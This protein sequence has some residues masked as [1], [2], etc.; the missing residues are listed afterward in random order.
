M[1][2]G[3]KERRVIDDM[4]DISA[5]HNGSPE[6]TTLSASSARVKQG[7][8]AL[9]FTN[10]VDYTKGEKNYPVG[11]PRADKNL[12]KMKLTDWSGYDFFECWV[13]AETSRESLPSVP[14]NVGFY[15]TGPKRSTSVP[16]G[17]VEKD[18]WVKIAIPISTLSDVA[19]IQRVQFSISEANY[20]HGDR[21]DFYIDDMVL[22]RFVQPAIAELA[23][24]RK[25]LYADAPAV[26]ASYRL[27]GYKGMDDV[28]A[29]FEIDHEGAPVATTAAKAARSGELTL[30]LRRALLPGNYCGR[31]SIRDGAGELIDQKQVEFQVIRGP[32][33]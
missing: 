17:E 28:R 7:K 32:F 14:L 21:V 23:M 24:Q 5:W 27:M 16:L 31:L 8:F 12:A 15:H 9:K 29:D 13:Y 22:T 33:P 2:E 30:P 4:E 26:T 19:D 18:A 3:N 6:E 10:V 11:W 20:K 1:S 25:I